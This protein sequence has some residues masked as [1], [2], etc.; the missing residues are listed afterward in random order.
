MCKD[1]FEQRAKNKEQR[2]KTI[3]N[4]LISTYLVLFGQILINQS[5]VFLAG[6]NFA[7]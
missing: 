7:A 1:F 3:Q 6:C 4:Q 5:L 2:Q